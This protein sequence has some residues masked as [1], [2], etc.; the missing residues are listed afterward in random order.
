MAR[1]PTSRQ[2]AS[3]EGRAIADSR[4]KNWKARNGVETPVEEDKTVIR[5]LEEQEKRLCKPCAPKITAGMRVRENERTELI[6]QETTRRKQRPHGQN[7]VRKNFTLS[8]EVALAIQDAAAEEGFTASRF[9]EDFMTAHP[10][11]DRHLRAAKL[12]R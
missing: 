5:F 11:V 10:T 6:P 1:N 2:P 12:D 7:T 3:E 9:I 4:R 8:E